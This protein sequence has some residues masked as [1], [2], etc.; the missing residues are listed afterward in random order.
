LRVR[1]IALAAA[2]A[3]VASAA[4]GGPVA[5]GA[6][7]SGAWGA[8]SRALAHAEVAHYASE[9]PP[10]V[11]AHCLAPAGDP[12]FGTPAWELR[13]VENQYCATLRLRDQLDSP[14][15]AYAQTTQSPGMY[16]AQ[17]TQ[18]FGEPGHLHGGITTLIPGAQVPDPFRTL[19]RWTA[20]GR[21]RVTAVAF[22]SSD[23]A[24]LR[25]HVFEPP[26]SDPP[27]PRGYP[28]VVITDG[29]VQAY[30]Q[31]YYWAAE[32]LAEAGY[33]VMTYDVQGQ[34]DSDL[35]PASC[36]G[37]SL[38]CQ[39]V[40]YQQSYNFFQG[41]EDSLNFFLASPA[42]PSGGSFNPYHAALNRDD[43]GIAGHSLGAAAVSEVG[44]CDRRV[45]T[46]VA[47][48]DLSAITGCGDATIPAADRSATLLHAPALALTNDYLF[49]IQPQMSIPDPH[50]KDDGYRQLVASGIDSEEVAFRGATHLTYSYIPYV[51]PASE[52]AERMAFHYTLA[53]FDRY[54][55]GN[56][57]GFSR[58]VAT[59][60]DSSA[61]RHSIGAG[62]YSLARALAH[63]GDPL[64]GNVPYVIAGIPVA[65][66][67][68][69]YYE[70]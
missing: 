36:P 61:D 62:T 37:P 67:V 70:S 16:A 52:L 12:A 17:L 29:S 38:S 51:L 26:A 24:Q 7:A 14:A 64:A 5:W 30:E 54:L 66:A 45:K 25:G 58:L 47:W 46:I 41:A 57:A 19:A 23:G 50:A 60:F 9:L 10:G 1:R 13:D 39:G 53:W 3:V 34:G 22:R 18:Q 65:N 11:Q 44:Q 28:G 27:P 31:L 69:F 56:R 20:A 15:Y 2:L 63:P 6:G 4:A 49:N 42:N 35:L 21:G 8:G 48:D 68:S 32:G 59:R 43:V 55:R 33:M 40:P